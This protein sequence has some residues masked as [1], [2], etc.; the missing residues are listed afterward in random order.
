MMQ[1]DWDSSTSPTGPSSTAFGQQAVRRTLTLWR[2][3]ARARRRHKLVGSAKIALREVASLRTARS[4]ARREREFDERHGVDTA[5]VVHLAA[6]EIAS[7]NKDLGVRYQAANPALVRRLLADIP[8]EPDEYVFVDFGAG[9]GRTAL[10]AS[11]F[12]FRRIMGVEFSPELVDVARANVGRFRSGAQLCRD[13]QF[14]CLDA[15]D[16]DIPTD[17]AVLFFYNPFGEPVMQRVM[18]RIRASLDEHPRATYVV[19]IG[20]DELAR[21]VERAGFVRIA[22]E[23]PGAGVFG[24]VACTVGWPD[25]TGQPECRSGSVIQQ[26]CGGCRTQP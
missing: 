16:L 26:P 3:L 2:R 6:L 25:A 9:K 1:P 21:L 14:V 13:I 15:V 11:E 18:E 8:I 5:G 24:T 12:P 23:G 10:L 20:D 4:E 19:L 17:P 22:G 7:P